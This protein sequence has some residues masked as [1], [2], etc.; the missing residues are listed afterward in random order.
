[1]R[2]APPSDPKPV[3]PT[4][5]ERRA[6]LASACV[7]AAITIVLG[8]LIHPVGT[9]GAMD[10]YVERAELLL[11]GSL[12][13][14]PFHSFLY[15]E[16]V[17]L[18]ALVVP[19]AFAA[20]RVVSGLAAGLFLFAA[21]RLAWALGGRRAAFW[22]SAWLA[23]NG[24]VLLLGV[25]AGSDMTAAALLMTSLWLL[26]DGRR[27]WPFG[28]GLFLGLAV[29]TRYNVGVVA[30]VLALLVALLADGS[31]GHRLRGVL[32]FVLAAVFGYLPNAIPAWLQ[33]GTPLP[34]ASWRSLAYKLSPDH[35]PLALVESSHTSLWSLLQVDGPRLVREAVADFGAIWTHGIGQC[36]GGGQATWFVATV[37]A[38]LSVLAI[39]SLAVVRP[40]RGQLVVVAVLIAWTGAVA[41]TFFPQNRLL[42]PVA[43]LALVAIVVALFEWLQPLAAHVAG[44][45]LVLLTAAT[46]PA[47]LRHFEAGH[48]MAE[49]AAARQLAEA[50]GPLATIASCYP[51]MA[52]RVPARTVYVPPP[53]AQRVDVASILQRLRDVRSRQPFDFAVIGRASVHGAPLDELRRNLPSGI[54]ARPGNAEV[55]VLEFASPGSEWLERAAATITGARSLHLE[56]ATSLDALTAGFTVRQ[57][58]V[59]P[60]LLPLLRVG[61]RRFE[62]TL[63]FES[64]STEGLELVPGCVLLTGEARQAPPI[65]VTGR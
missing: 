48:P 58:N 7:F 50:H 62:A 29:A 63:P 54:T 59:S 24:G 26:L 61:P 22:T 30:P 28:S 19:D 15:T 12:V 40:A 37:F 25:E 64:G 34:S 53:P 42:I 49:I 41:A 39:G 3:S 21:A 11:Q 4:S 23:C 46:V 13:A 16:L 56:I 14:D 31:C 57:P 8:C 6:A 38:A 35:D 2:T 43:P 33:F 27:A 9:G 36:L 17:A 32:Q 5:A 20:G 52:R 47:S 51:L 10:Q 1:M 44:G 45:V 60:W 65:T 55:V 18:V